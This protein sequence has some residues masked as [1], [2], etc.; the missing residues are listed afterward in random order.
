[1]ELVFKNKNSDVLEFDLYNI[2]VSFVNAIRRIIL[3]ELDSY[4]FETSDY[5]DSKVKIIENTS[6]LHNEFILHRIGLIPIHNINDPSDYKFILNVQ[7]N[8]NNIIDVT[9]KD[10]EV[11]NLKTNIKEDSLKFFPPNP[12][13]GD[14]ILIIRLKPN[15][16]EDGEKLHIEG[17]VSKGTGS[18]N[19]RYSLVSNVRFINKIDDEKYKDALDKHLSNINSDDIEKETNTF[20]INER[21]RYFH[22]D[23]FGNPNKFEFTIESIGIHSTYIILK[24][25]LEKLIY[26]INTFL[27]NFKKAINKQDSII[28]IKESPTVMKATD[29]IIPNETHTLGFILQSYINKNENISYISYNNPHP[30]KNEI[31]IRISTEENIQP[32]IEKT[33]SE[34]TNIANEFIKTINSEFLIKPKKKI[35]IKKK[36]L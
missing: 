9:T 32:I 5:T 24:K 7:N 4:A 35:L 3:S 34:I 15:P 6:S 2:D 30:L 12:I 8:T 22:T 31:F 13:T 17:F 25:A 10:I 18:D 19:T 28:S 29:I 14:N 1:M 23:E 33:C 20:N 21:E 26:K 16:G 36:K 27:I 11:I